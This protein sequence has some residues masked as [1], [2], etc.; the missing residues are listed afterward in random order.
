VWRQ[1]LTADPDQIRRQ[2][3][4]RKVSRGLTAPAPRTRDL[5][6][7]DLPEGPAQRED[8]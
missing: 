3:L 5:P 4:E 1:A 8:L 6:R 7:V 2:S